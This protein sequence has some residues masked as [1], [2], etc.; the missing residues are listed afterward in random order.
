MGNMTETKCTH[1]KYTWNTNSKLNLVTCP[2]CG[3]KT[4]KEDDTND[5]EHKTTKP[6]KD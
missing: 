4:P 1:C 5:M 6:P 2:N 3:K